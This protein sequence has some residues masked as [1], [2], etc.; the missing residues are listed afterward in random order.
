VAL[1]KIAIFKMMKE[2]SSLPLKGLSKG[3]RD[4]SKLPELL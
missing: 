1:V 3:Q 2:M 4:I